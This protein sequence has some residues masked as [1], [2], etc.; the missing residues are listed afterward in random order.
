MFGSI[1]KMMPQSICYARANLKHN[2]Q[3]YNSHP[4]IEL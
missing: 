4:K 1:L 3:A 2:L